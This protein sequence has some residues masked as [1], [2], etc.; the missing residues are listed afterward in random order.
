MKKFTIILFT[1]LG[2]ASF[3]SCKK[4]P[5][6]CASADKTSALTD[7]S[8]TFTSCSENSERISW[9]FGDGNTEE[10]NSV[11][12]SYSKAGTYLVKMVAYSKKDKDWDKTAMIITV[13][14]PPVA[15]VPAKRYLTKIVL[16]VVP[17]KN[18]SGND[19]DDIFGIT[20]TADVYVALKLS[21]G[22]WSK[23]TSIKTDI[24]TGDLPYTWNL[25]P[26]NIYLSSD[27]WDVEVRDDEGAGFSELMNAW[28]SINLATASSTGGIISLAYGTSPNN[29][30]LDI[31]FEER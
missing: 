25:N 28:T 5:L 19:W 3:S 18:S 15:P 21:S 1:V 24:S 29:Y 14:A 2:L 7:E 30:S 12:H 11:T 6:S 26:D 4:D 10:G 20:S 9:D 27:N 13:S 31:Y 8:I 16:K 17:A 22:S 23:S